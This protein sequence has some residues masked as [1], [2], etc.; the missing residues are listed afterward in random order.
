[1]VL[2][3][4]KSR[5]YNDRS[6]CRKIFV[7]KSYPDINVQLCFLRQHLKG[8]ADFVVETVT[9]FF[10]SSVSE[11]VSKK[12]LGYMTLWLQFNILNNLRINYQS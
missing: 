6:S 12:V 10:F 5:W 7:K 8:L 2:K 9:C 11:L 1:M 4:G 3:L